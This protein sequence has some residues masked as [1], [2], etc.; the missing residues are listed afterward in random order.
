MFSL[1]AVTYPPV[2]TKSTRVIMLDT[3]RFDVPS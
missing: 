2:S 3:E 1:N